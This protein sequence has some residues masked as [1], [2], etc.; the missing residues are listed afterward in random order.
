[1]AAPSYTE[2]LTDIDLAQTTT[3]WLQI[4]FA[5]G[6]GG[7]IATG[8]D[9]AMQG[10][11]C[12]DRQVTNNERGAMYNNTTGITL[13]A[14]DH[15]FQWGFLATPGVSDTLAVRGAYTIC[16]TGTGDLVQF[17][18]DGLDTYGAQGRVGKCYAYRYVTTANTTSI[19]YRTVTG[20]PGSNPQYFGFGVKTTATVKGANI[21]VDAIRYGTG[22]Y[23]TA[24]ELISA[25]DGSD[26]PC[27]FRDFATTNDYNDATNGYNRWGILSASG[28]SNYELQGRFVVGQNN[29]QTATLARFR[30]SNVNISLIDTAHSLTDFT[31]FIIDHASTRCEW[32]NI[33]ITALGGHNPGQ[34]QVTSNN[35]TFILAGGTFTDLGVTVLR[36]NTTATGST[37]FRCDEVTANGASLNDSNITHGSKIVDAQ[38]ETNYGSPSAFA[39]G[40]GYAVS[41]IIYMFDGSRITVDAVSTGAVTQFTVDSADAKRVEEGTL[42]QSATSGSGS[43]FTLTPTGQNY[44]ESS[45]LIWDVN[46]D[47]DGE[48]DGM[49][50]DNITPSM[51]HA[52]EFGTNVPTTMTL[53]NCDFGTNYSATED[54]SAG[55]ETFW[56]RDT[57]PTSITLNLVGCSGNFGYKTDGAAI[58]IVADPVTTTVTVL[59]NTGS[60]LL[61]ARVILRAD[62]SPGTLPYQ[63]TVSISRT[64]STATVSHTGHGLSV[65]QKVEIKGANEQDYNGVKTITATTTNTYDFE[66]DSPFPSSPATGTITSTAIILEGTTDSSGQIT[67]SRTFSVAQPVSGAPY[68]RASPLTGTISTTNGLDLTAQLILDQ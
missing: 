40:T 62:G 32:S 45:A 44:T 11:L 42:T 17:H 65:N 68:Y 30:D 64:G 66:M 61:G 26:D 59:D 29:S 60:P 47:P 53:R 63:E 24:G 9:F 43:G 7:T 6:G 67:D 2:D 27:N 12:V 22:A 49:T 31:Q 48:L 58:T 3:N 20:T 23:L 15:I 21:G 35:P 51:T 54:G 19:P 55:N 4:N 8:A 38:D 56:F 37:W 16:G 28:G 14:N 36:S 18:V 34:I 1:V 25:G 50:F 52:V 41:D 39:G 13:G 46:S 10:T 57:S 5:G 33:N